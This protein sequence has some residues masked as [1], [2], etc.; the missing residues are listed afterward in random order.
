MHKQSYDDILKNSFYPVF[1]A[2]H[3]KYNYV[4]LS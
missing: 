4:E 3:L 1:V 2:F